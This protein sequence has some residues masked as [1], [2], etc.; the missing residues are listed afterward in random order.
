[1]KVLIITPRIPYPPF[2]G[3]KLK[4]FNISKNLLKRNEV[5]ILTF[6]NRS[7]ELND[8][9]QLKKNGIDIDTIRLSS[10]TSYLTTSRSLLTLDPLQVSYYYSKKMHERIEKIT[11]TEKFDLIYFHLI[12]SAQY[13]KSVKDESALKVIDF[14]DAVS[15]YLSR[16]VKVLKN[17]IK[18]IVFYYEYKSI[19]RYE[20][21]AR[22]FDT[23][24]ICSYNDKEFLERRKIHDNIQILLNGFDSDSFKSEKIEPEKDRI[25]FSGN[26]PYFPNKD[27]VLYFVNE[28]FPLVLKIKPKAKFY[29]V[30]QQPPKEI[31]ALQSDNI[32]VTGFVED[33]RK[34]YLL[35]QINVA[36]IR[37]GAGTL[38]KIIESLALGIPTIATSLSIQ[39]FPDE[40]KK[41]IFTADTPEAFANLILKILD[42]PNIRDEM[43]SA[44]EKVFSMLN[45]EKI[46]NDFEEYIHSRIIKNISK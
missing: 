27:A 19:S 20:K 6:I 16:Y 12:S 5:K 37:F 3:D 31:L 41:Y 36:P 10:I 1:M 25:I 34:E 46:V 45:W 30:G 33:I 18:K 17:P 35:S 23:L 21:I 32:I 8:V 22:E 28:I 2:R 38:N 4:I 14:T 43:T 11:S 29:I 9:E 26:M 24:F 44:S 15:L 7:S 13:L 40:L 39:G 42:N